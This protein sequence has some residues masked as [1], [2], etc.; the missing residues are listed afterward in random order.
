MLDILVG[1]V[2]DTLNC[3]FN[4]GPFIERR[5]NTES[6]LQEYQNTNVF[7][8]GYGSSED[9]GMLFFIKHSVNDPV[10]NHH[11]NQTI[12]AHIRN[13]R[14]EFSLTQDLIGKEMTN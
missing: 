8:T 13:N 1:L 9:S 11:F 5:D 10:K 14:T 4:I 6:V 2:A 12:P 3:L 7:S